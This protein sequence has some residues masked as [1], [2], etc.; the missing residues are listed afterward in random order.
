MT[1][2]LVI[3]ASKGI[4]LATVKAGLAA[5]FDVRALARGAGAIAIMDK[6]LEKIPASALDAAAIAKAVAGTDAVVMSIGA[7]RLFEKVTLFSQAT[8]ILIDAMG[9]AG[10]RRLLVVTGI[11]AG[12]SRGH[13][14]FF[15]DQIMFPILLKRVY[16]D[17]DTQ[18][19][20]VRQSGLDWT[21]ARPGMLTNGP[22]KGKYRALTNMQDWGPGSVSRADVAAYLIG[23][24]A[25]P[26]HIGKTPELIN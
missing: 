12:D 8:R 4:G 11:G 7:S 15:Y 10:A 23:E 9:K 21:I 18:E 26:K 1:T 5:G 20:M 25:S 19:M 2:L 24:I 6:R 16:D 17:K 3:G 22:A 14:G 13:G